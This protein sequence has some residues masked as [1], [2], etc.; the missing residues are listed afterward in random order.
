MSQLILQFMKQKNIKKEGYLKN[1]EKIEKNFVIVLKIKKKCGKLN[2]LLKKGY[3]AFIVATNFY[4][5]F[6]N[7]KSF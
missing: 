1:F 4:D 2:K 3:S 7:K 6:I 5:K